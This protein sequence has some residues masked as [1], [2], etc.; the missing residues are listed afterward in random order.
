MH[1]E[2]REFIEQLLNVFA[3]IL[4]IACKEISARKCQ[5]H[6]QAHIAKREKKEKEKSLWEH[7]TTYSIIHSSYI[8]KGKVVTDVTEK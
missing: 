4:K 3:K 5:N 6:A 7:K 8:H 1:I 2:S